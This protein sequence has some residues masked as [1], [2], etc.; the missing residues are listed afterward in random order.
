[1]ETER[2][3]I[4][5]GITIEKRDDGTVKEIR[6]LGIVFNKESVDMGG[7]REIISPDAMRNINLNQSDVVSLF[8]HDPNN[9]LA[10]T[11]DTL[12][13]EQKSDGVYYSFAPNGTR[14]SNDLVTNLERKEVRGS[15]FVFRVA[16]G[17]D[18]WEKHPSGD[19]WIRTIN[20]FSGIFDIGPV[21]FPA[22]PDT[23]VAKRSFENLNKDIFPK[24]D[25]VPLELRQQKAEI[26]KLYI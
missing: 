7:W 15:S 24:T 11:P 22:Y 21:T 19:Y 16:D 17:G 14:A 5:E 13:L 18:T 2:R 20:E 1:M 23:T 3:F 26:L 6:G 10:R 25:E 9:V 8:N 4:T 12:T